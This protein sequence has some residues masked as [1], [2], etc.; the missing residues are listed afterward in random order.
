MWHGERVSEWFNKSVSPTRGPATSLVISDSQ[1]TK[2]GLFSR[3]VQ[4]EGGCGE[5]VGQK[6]TSWFCLLSASLQ[7]RWNHAINSVSPVQ[8]RDVREQL[9]RQHRAFLGHLS[10]HWVSVLWLLNNFLRYH[11]HIINFPRFTHTISSYFHKIL[12]FLHRQSPALAHSHHPQKIPVPTCGHTPLP[13]M[14]VPLP[15]Q[16]QAVTT[17][18]S[19]FA[20]F[21]S[22]HSM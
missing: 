12:Q 22:E 15:P 2:Q 14:V 1:W 17:L 5:W 18:P 4:P 9:G 11:L 8:P 10:L 20:D 19:A 21:L 16:P 13:P 6:V 3:N 7:W